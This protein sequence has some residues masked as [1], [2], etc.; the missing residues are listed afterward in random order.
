MPRLRPIHSGRKRRHHP[1]VPGLFLRPEGPT[2]TLRMSVLLARCL[3]RGQWFR[4]GNAL[5]RIE[6]SVP[7][8][9][10]WHG[11]R[12]GRQ[13]DSLLRPDRHGRATTLALHHAFRRAMD[14]ASNVSQ[15]F[16][17]AQAWCRGLR[18]SVGARGHR[19]CLSGHHIHFEPGDLASA[20]MSVKEVL[21]MRPR[22]AQRRRRDRG[23]SSRLRTSR[24]IPHVG[25]L[26]PPSV[27]FEEQGPRPVWLSSVD[28]LDHVVARLRVPSYGFSGRLERD[29]P[30]GSRAKRA[31]RH[32][33]HHG[34]ML[35]AVSRP[36]ALVS[37]SPRRSRGCG[38][39]GSEGR[40][41]GDRPVFRGS[42]PAGCPSRGGRVLHQ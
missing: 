24:R 6:Y 38:C 12:R 3:L 37:H 4:G 1:R 10:T 32:G 22:L 26:S 2:S 35:S 29:L 27:A 16:C 25:S 30:L 31:V 9:R 42:R 19:G 34:S 17:A 15:A 33:W 36:C 7:R 40:V 11:C 23:T 20:F 5:P 28:P 8:Y 21:A 18:A 39:V 13:V 14:A 41:V